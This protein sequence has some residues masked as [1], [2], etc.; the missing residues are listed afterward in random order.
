MGGRPLPPLSGDACHVPL[1][2]APTRSMTTS[3]SPTTSARSARRPAIGS[4]TSCDGPSPRPRA[5]ILKRGRY[6]SKQRTTAWA[7]LVV[8]AILTA[9]GPLPAVQTMGLYFLPLA[10]LTYIGLVILAFGGLGLVLN[11]VAERAVSLRRGGGAG[12]RPRAGAPARAGRDLRGAGDPISVRRPLRIPRPR[13]GRAAD[14]RGAV[15]RLPGRREAR[16]DD[17]LP[18]GRLRHRPS[19]CRTTRRRRSSS[20]ASSTS[21]PTSASSAATPRP[22]A[23]PA[24]AIAAVFAV[25]GIFAV[26]IWNLYAFGRFSPLHVSTASAVAVGAVGAIGLGGCLLWSL[27]GRAGEGPAEAR[28]AQRRGPGPGRGRSSP[29]SAASA[30][31]SATTA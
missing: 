5:E 24:K 17:L 9:L 29:T 21:A 4:R 31:R 23:S 19:T 12:R 2:Q 28:G 25:V 14:R 6:A 7:M 3:S 15:E 10:Y 11:A 8:G 26:L 20:T 18:R 1:G 30:G 13:D 22:T 16:A 27:R